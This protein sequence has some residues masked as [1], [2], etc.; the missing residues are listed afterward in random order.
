MFGSSKVL[1]VRQGPVFTV[2]HVRP[3]TWFERFLRWLRA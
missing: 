3:L 1:R 2:L